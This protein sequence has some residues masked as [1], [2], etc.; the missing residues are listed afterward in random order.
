MKTGKILGLVVLLTLIALVPML[1]AAVWASTVT[2]T[3]ETI[4]SPSANGKGWFVF[5]GLRHNFAFA[6]KEG[7]LN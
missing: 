7:K 6:A 3:S 4:S 1:G 5:N 2:G